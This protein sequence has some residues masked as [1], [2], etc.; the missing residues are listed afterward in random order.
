MERWELMTF[1]VLEYIKIIVPRSCQ[2]P[3]YLGNIRVSH[4]KGTTEQLE[5]TDKTVII[6]RDE[7]PKRR[8]ND[9]WNRKH[10]Q[11]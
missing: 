10:I 6:L 2:S 7:Y 11:L 4:K 3:Y 5:I 1:Y 9:L 8:E